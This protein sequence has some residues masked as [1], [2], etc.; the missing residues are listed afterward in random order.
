MPTPKN[1]QKTSNYLEWKLS[2][3]PKGTNLQLPNS[4]AY[5]ENE[6]NIKISKREG[7][8]KKTLHTIKINN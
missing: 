1:Q 3:S 8:K 4:A 5:T 6:A 2:F 7:K